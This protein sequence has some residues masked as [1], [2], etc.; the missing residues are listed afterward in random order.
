M[1]ASTGGGVEATAA[2]GGPERAGCQ[3]RLA[4]MSSM[5]MFSIFSFPDDDM[6]DV[7]EK[8]KRWRRVRWNEKVNELYNLTAFH[9]Y[10]HPQ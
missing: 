7:L 10:L 4:S 9:L 5:P 6:M 1:E 8:M 3:E 2:G